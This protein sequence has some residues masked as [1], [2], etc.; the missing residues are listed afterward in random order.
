MSQYQNIKDRVTRTWQLDRI[1]IGHSIVD[2]HAP[3]KLK[4]QNDTEYVRLHFGLRGSYDFHYTQ[5]NRSYSL[6]GHHNNIMYSKGLELEITNKTNRIETFG[7]DFE[8]EAFVE[9]GQNGNDPLKRFTADV[10]NEKNAILSP[11]WR[12]N[13][14]RIQEVIS[15]IVHCTFTDGLRD[16]FLLSKSIE[17]LVLQADLYQEEPTVR[18]IKSER[19]RKR[20]IE[21]RELLSSRIGDPPTV[22]ELSRLTGIN[23]YKLKRGFKELFG[24]TIFGFIHRSRMDLAKRLL[25]HTDKPIKEIAYETGYS[26]PQHFSTAFKKQFG[27]TPN[28]IRKGT[29]PSIT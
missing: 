18:Y 27:T 4:A 26:S 24:T 5:L 9:I 29:D 12:T 23:E 8:P 1:Q 22:V 20:F 19:D 15:D 6:A 28:G 2:Y 21:V 17:L 14:F 11:H 7:I 16:L 3:G 25:L 10:V 13:S